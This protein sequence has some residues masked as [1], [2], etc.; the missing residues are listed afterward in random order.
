MH[1]AEPEQEQA[2]EGAS[3][4]WVYHLHGLTVVMMIMCGVCQVHTH[5]TLCEVLDEAFKGAV[6]RKAH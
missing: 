5:P 4:L 2:R 1:S 6:G 3:S